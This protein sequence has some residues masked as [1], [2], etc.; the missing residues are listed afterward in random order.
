MLT[1]RLSESVEKVDDDYRRLYRIMMQ[2]LTDYTTTRRGHRY[3]SMLWASMAPKGNIYRRNGLFAEHRKHSE[4]LW[5]QM[6]ELAD[7][8]QGLLGGCDVS[9]EQRA[10][11]L[12]QAMIHAKVIGCAQQYPG[13]PEF[14]DPEMLQDQ[15]FLPLQE[16]LR[17]KTWRFGPFL[18]NRDPE[19]RQQDAKHITMALGV[20][21][22]Q[23]IAPFLIFLNRWHQKTN[24]L[25]PWESLKEHLTW[26]QLF[27]MGTTLSD[28]LTTIMGVLLLFVIIFMVRCYVKEQIESATKS[29]KLPTDAG[30]F[31]MGIF[32]NAW[33]CCFICLDIP[34][35]FWSEETPTNIVL[36]S[37]TLLFL[38][39]LDD[40]SDILCSYLNLTDE[41]FQ[42]LAS[43]NSA[44]L[45]QCPVRLEDLIVADAASL[46]ELWSI[47]YDKTGRLCTTKGGQC[48][49]RLSHGVSDATATPH[50]ETSPLAAHK[51]HQC[52]QR[53]IYCPSAGR[54]YELPSM[55]ACSMLMMWNLVSW[56]LAVVQFIIPL[57]W[58]LINKR[59][60]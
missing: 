54:L 4:D 8:H 19:V 41:D 42:R 60:F 25:R 35:L 31:L 27:C 34:L 57:G 24:Y 39:K 51:R 13:E 45:S 10:D 55:L 56:L 17:E 16:W 50:S 37:M 21:G 29:G 47:R 38:F 5:V 2:E 18:L 46:G 1:Q 58:Y 30:W 22:L 53:I 33:S 59:C 3:Y 20:F 32:A 15:G 7:K 44:L 6:Y 14:K 52:G 48:L 12:Y 23:V 36:D 43:W 49:M 40:L 28:V 11:R 9:R 26:K